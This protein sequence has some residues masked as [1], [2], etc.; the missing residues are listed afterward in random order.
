[1]PSMLSSVGLRPNARTKAALALEAVSLPS[2]A[3][4]EDEIGCK[5]VGLTGRP[6]TREPLF[7]AGDESDSLTALAG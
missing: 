1:M 5:N 2:P 6:G 3:V 4:D 7:P